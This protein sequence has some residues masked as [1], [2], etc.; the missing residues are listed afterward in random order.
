MTQKKQKLM[1]RRK[2]VYHAFYNEL[3][4]LCFPNTW[5]ERDSTVTLHEPEKAE[6]RLRRVFVH[7]MIG[8][9]F[10][11][12][13][14]D[15]AAEIEVER[16]FPT[17]ANRR[18]Q[19]LRNWGASTERLS[20]KQGPDLGSLAVDDWGP[21]VDNEDEDE[22]D[23]GDEFKDENED[24]DEVD[25]TNEPDLPSFPLAS[26]IY[27]LKPPNRGMLGLLDSIRPD[28][29]APKFSLDMLEDYAWGIY[30]EG[31]NPEISEVRIFVLDPDRTISAFE[32]FGAFKQKHRIA[33]QRQ[34]REFV[35]ELLSVCWRFIAI[36]RVSPEAP[37]LNDQ[38]VNAMYDYIKT[39]NR[40]SKY[41]AGLSQ[42]AAIAIRQ[43]NVKDK[44]SPIV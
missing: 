36:A 38:L 7:R 15:I 20:R 33:A 9:A 18:E 29:F 39:T 23:E 21:E 40:G 22:R 19:I 27:K 32:L 37:D 30:L 41:E 5:V 12:G 34:F 16:H 3:G 6:A 11:L 10:Q 31:L 8:S 35:P 17:V 28:S 1:K 25:E 13:M 43:Y 14:L 44:S 2:V 26:G 42:I 4:A 24:E